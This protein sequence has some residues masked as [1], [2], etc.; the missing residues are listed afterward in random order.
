MAVVW[1][2]ER[3]EA[4]AREIS[5]GG[6]TSLCRRALTTLFDSELDGDQ[7]ES[8]LVACDSEYLVL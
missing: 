8:R 6:I 7:S 3:I 5:N 4:R 2:W 1:A